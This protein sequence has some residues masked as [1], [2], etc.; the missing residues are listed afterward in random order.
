MNHKTRKEK[1][2]MLNALK[3]GKIN[4]SEFYELNDIRPYQ[5]P[6]MYIQ[7]DINP[8]L[9]RC[10]KDGELMKYSDI[11]EE[12]KKYKS[13]GRITAIFIISKPIPNRENVGT[14][15]LDFKDAQ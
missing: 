7:D 15:I 6:K 12:R 11:K 4:S 2:Q 5:P 9:F 13:G 14:I 3:S 10:G 8:E 1:I